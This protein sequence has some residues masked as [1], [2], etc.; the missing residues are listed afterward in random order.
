[1]SGDGGGNDGRIIG[2]VIVGFVLL[3]AII[4]FTI[5]LCKRHGK[6]ITEWI[7]IS[8]L[9]VQPSWGDKMSIDFRDK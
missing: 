1:M 6:Y 4:I 2:G 7:L 3:I 9:V 5:V 8:Y